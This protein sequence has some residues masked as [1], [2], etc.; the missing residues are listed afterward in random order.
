MG[1]TLPSIYPVFLAPKVCLLSP[2]PGKQMGKGPEPVP[3]LPPLMIEA[4]G[5]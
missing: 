1:K 4:T 5:Y 3:I 2:K